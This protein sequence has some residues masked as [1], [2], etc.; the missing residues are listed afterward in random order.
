MENNN[1]KK[2][3]GSMK[4][5]KV[6]LNSLVSFSDFGNDVGQRG[7]TQSRNGNANLVDCLKCENCGHSYIPNEEIKQ[8]KFSIGQKV[9]FK[10]SGKRIKLTISEITYR[11]K[12]SL[13]DIMGVDFI[14]DFYYFFENTYLS[15]SE[16][17]L[18]EFNK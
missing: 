3:N 6:L 13:H 9:Y 10:I 1:C 8:A 4:E 18:L 12:D 2:C 11:E 5:S 7:T 16:K 17:Q 14:P 15:T